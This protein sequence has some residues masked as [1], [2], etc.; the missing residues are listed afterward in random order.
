MWGDERVQ[1]RWHEG[2]WLAAM[3]PPSFEGI[4]I[5]YVSG[6]EGYSAILFVLRGGRLTGADI[7]GVKYVG[8]YEA[9]ANSL[10]GQLA[11]TYPPNSMTITGHSTG[12]SPP[13]IQVPFELKLEEIG[14]GFIRLDT[15]VGPVTASIQY[16]QELP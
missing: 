4:Y 11:V 8:K 7:G 13:S 6:S 12:S 5:A 1:L 2:D 10:R 3:T 14:K 16:V 15:P 9:G